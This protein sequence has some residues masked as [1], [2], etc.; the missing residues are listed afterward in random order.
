M[1]TWSFQQ[2]QRTNTLFKRYLYNQLDW[3]ARLNIIVGM[4]GVGKTTM[5]LQHAREHLPFDNSVIYISIDD[6]YFTTN[7]LI[8]F[9]EEFNKRGGKYLLIDEVQKYE[10]WSREVK[11]IYDNFP[12]I[13]ITV[14]GSS[15]IEILKGEG[16]LSRRAIINRLQGLSFREFIEL[17]YQQ[18]FPVWTLSE[19]LKNPVE[20]AFL[21][22]TKIK[23]IKLFEEYIQAGYYPFAV[24]DERNFQQRMMQI[25]NTIIETDIPAVNSIDYNAVLKMKKL[26]GIIAESVPF[27]PNITKLANQLSLSRETFLKYLQL[28]AKADIIS[29]MYSLVKGVSALNKP[30]KI[31]L[32]N[33]N[34]AYLLADSN[35]NT[36]N[37]RETFFMNQ[38]QHIHNVEYPVK[39]DFLVDETYTF[40]V[41]GKNKT[42]QQIAGIENAYVVADNIEIPVGNKIPLWM[43]GFLY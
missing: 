14:S 30:E 41:G 27:K 18:P 22:A 9:A 1:F 20:K 28:L 3:N 6:I 23:P 33:P 5:M 31:Y 24:E 19:I 7:S 38:L 35:A 36:G 13:Q 40:E 8:D 11:M 16:D 37:I 25:I 15:A 43:F 32:N 21:I 39:G 2:I 29:L 12:E 26:L 10:G 4:R 34:I 17:K 42:T